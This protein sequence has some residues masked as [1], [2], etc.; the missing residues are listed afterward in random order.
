[1]TTLISPASLRRATLAALATNIGIVITG[2]VVRVTGSGLGCPNWPQCEPGS[3]VPT[4]ASE[5]TN[6]QTAI[7]FGNRLLTFIVLAAVIWVVVALRRHATDMPRLRRVAWLL[8]AGVLTQ[9]IIGGITVLTG[10]APIAVAVHF[11][12]SMALIAV[13]M[14]VHREV[15]AH[16]HHRPAVRSVQHLT[17]AVVAVTSVVLLLG[18]VVT[19]AGPHGGDTVAPRLPVNIRLVAIAHADM[20]WLLLGLTVALLVATRQ[21]DTA[22]RHSVVALLALQLTQG[23]IGYVQYWLG[24]P[25]SVVSLHIAGAAI[26]WAF[27]INVF[28]HARGPLLTRTA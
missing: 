21:A 23:G 3:L 15:T 7:E 22:L 1:M 24:I 11:L 18:T 16:A 20:V 26:L 25:A 28:W 2:G 14:L 13:A 19:G 4:V 8:P 6:W 27:T 5:H 9:A 10:L 12:L 17:T